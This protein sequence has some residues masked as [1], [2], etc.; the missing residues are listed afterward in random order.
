VVASFDNPP[1]DDK[2]KGSPQVFSPFGED[3]D[4]YENSKVYPFTPEELIGKTIMRE[5][6]NGDILRSEIVRMLKK[7]P[8]TRANEPSFSL[9]P[10]TA[11]HLPKK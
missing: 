10:R 6:K 2:G 5:D 4:D 7:T 3:K 8:K 9:K 1:T 11:M